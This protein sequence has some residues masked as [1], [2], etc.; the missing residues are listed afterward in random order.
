M[1]S[2]TRWLTTSLLALASVGLT[3][4]CSPHRYVDD[5]DTCSRAK[6]LPPIVLVKD[7]LHVPMGDRSD[8]KQVKYFK[9]A[10]ARVEVRIGSAFERHNLKGLLTVY[11]GDGQVVDQKAVDPS[12]FKYSFEFAVVANKPYF[13]EFKVNEGNFPYSAQVQFVKLDP[14]AQCTADQDCV[15]GPTGDKI[16]RERVKVCEPE[17]NPEESYCEEGVC[18]PFCNPPCTRRNYQCNIETRECERVRRTC[19]PRCRR[20]KVCRRGRCVPR[21]APQACAGGCAPGQVCRSGRCV[22]RGQATEQCPACPNPSDVCGPQTSYRCVTQGEDTPTGP[23]TGRVASTV[24]AGNRTIVYI[25]RGT[26]HGVKPG[27]RGK[28]CDRFSFTITNAFATRSKGTTSVTIE[29]LGDCK[30]VRITR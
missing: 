7:E 29:E 6:P 9:D 13:L 15:D 23:I 10:I 18:I 12:V 8:C 16:C 2:T 5:D 28:L 3:A 4:A 21:A 1:R 26:R 11:D 14:C 25:N 27:Q 17:C 22:T 30:S 20:G 19:S 24:R